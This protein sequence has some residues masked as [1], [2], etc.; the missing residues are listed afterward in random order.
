MGDDWGDGEMVEY[1]SGKASD[2]VGLGVSGRF[3]E[4]TPVAQEA[5]R[6]LVTCIGEARS[7]GDGAKGFEMA[8]NGMS[9]LGD[10]WE[11]RDE[12]VIKLEGATGVNGKND[13]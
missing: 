3:S 13:D 9:D 4:T 7:G 11:S 1:V 5:A 8:K 6:S 12:A 10:D 2:A